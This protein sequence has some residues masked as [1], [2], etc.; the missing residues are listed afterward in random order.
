MISKEL[1]IKK[2]EEQAT[3]IKHLV[4]KVSEEN[5]G[6]KLTPAQ[7]TIKELVAY[8]A[9]SYLPLTQAILDDNTDGF[10]AART[11][12]ETFDP[13]NFET[14]FDS[15]IDAV[16]KMIDATSQDKLEETTTLFG[17]TVDTRAGHLLNLILGGLFTYKTQ[18][19]LQLK[20]HGLDEL[21]T[22]NLRGGM[23]APKKD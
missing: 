23:D 16:I 9:H 1:F 11:A 14:Q 3:I 17:R 19:F 20:H 2:V 13:A 10:A 15:Q 4:T 18:L 6:H 7:R 22:S 12:A 8:L 5:H 21:Q